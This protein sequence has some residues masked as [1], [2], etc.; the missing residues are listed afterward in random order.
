M[1]AISYFTAWWAGEECDAADWGSEEDGGKAADC[2]PPSTQTSVQAS[3]VQ[4]LPSSHS[5]LGP[6]TCPRWES[7]HVDC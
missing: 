2:P 1:F 4:T 5:S 6:H 3:S 7:C